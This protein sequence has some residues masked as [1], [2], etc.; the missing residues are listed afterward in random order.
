MGRS[1]VVFRIRIGQEKRGQAG[2]KGTG[3]LIGILPASR[4][5]SRIA[6]IRHSAAPLRTLC[7]CAQAPMQLS[8]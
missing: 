4:A 1:N 3:Y 8:T 5:V 2:E 6:R 7:L